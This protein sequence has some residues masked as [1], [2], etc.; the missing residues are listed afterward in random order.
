LTDPPVEP[1]LEGIDDLDRADLA[2]PIP[3]DPAGVASVAP[4]PVS[5]ATMVAAGEAP[6]QAK[7]VDPSAFAV[8]KAAVEP[9]PAEERAGYAARLF[10]L[11]FAA[12]SS[13]VMVAVAA[14]L[15]SFGLSLRQV[16]VAVVAGV[17]LSALPLGLGSLAGKWS[18]QPTMVVSRATFG[19]V[20]NVLP[21][22]LAVIGRVLWGAVLLW[23]LAVTAA[24]VLA[25]EQ[26]GLAV[27]GL[28]SLAVGAV[29]A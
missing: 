5:T 3:V 1:E 7:P 28:V 8:E 2:A 11:W 25:P 14:S 24:A 6:E 22:V 4:V 13:M 26:T 16:L 19:L 20:G 23:L 12:N 9:T 29:L 10:W 15:F 21:A 18:G 27:T 17:C